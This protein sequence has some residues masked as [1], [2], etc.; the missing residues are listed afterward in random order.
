MDVQLIASTLLEDVPTE[1][2]YVTDEADYV[3]G[4]NLVEYAGRGCY[5]SFNRP[6]PKT[7]NTKAYVGNL[8]KQGHFSVL[9]HANAT[10]RITGVSRSLTHELVRHRH[11]A[12]SQESQ[13]YVYQARQF[14]VP[15][16]LE[17]DEAGR[18]LWR[19]AV[20]HAYA[21]YEGLVAHLI[22]RGMERKRVHET[23]RSVLPQSSATSITVT[24]NY[25]AWWEFC[26]KRTVVG[27][28]RE[29]RALAFTIATRLQ[30][31]DPDVW[32]HWF[33]SPDELGY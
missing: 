25:R 13:R 19:D 7:V 33:K 12:F 8:I 22:E 10:F 14:V 21:V 24:G 20:T 15:P 26:A 32:D 28:D 30:A 17:A 23:A 1:W 31:H 3:D 11:L 16:A 4:S 29:I 2:R 27:A 18:R 5:L 6:N 9:E